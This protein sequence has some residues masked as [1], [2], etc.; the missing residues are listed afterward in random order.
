M[1]PS[2]AK[3]PAARKKTTIRNTVKKSIGK[4]TNKPTNKNRVS[5]PATSRASYN[6]K[7]VEA[8][9]AKDARIVDKF[10]ADLNRQ[11]KLLKRGPVGRAIYDTQGFE[12]DYT[13]VLKSRRRPQ[14]ARGRNSTSYMKMIEKDLAQDR[15]VEG[16]IGLPENGL[17]G[18]TVRSAVQDRVA[19]DL[20]VPWHKIDISHYGQWKELG[21]KVDPDEFKLENIPEQER[22]RLSELS[23]GSALRK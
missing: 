4:T 22:E 5:K 15:E 13:K 20:D 10:Q 6:D 23:S 9:R 14:G 7:A 19:R 3:K 16:I 21:F 17:S 1:A 11:E 18:S 8:R 12:L 2:R